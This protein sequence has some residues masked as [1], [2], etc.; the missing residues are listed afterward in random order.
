MGKQVVIQGGEDDWYE[1]AIFLLRHEPPKGRMNLV[2][3]ANYIIGAYM[4]TSAVDGEEK[5]STLVSK[6]NA[7]WID[8]LFYGGLVLLVITLVIYLI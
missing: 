4:K 7:K 5:K 2:S 6:R 1:K 8:M 3:E